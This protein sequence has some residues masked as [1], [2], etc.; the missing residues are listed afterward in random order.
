MYAAGFFFSLRRDAIV[1]HQSGPDD[2]HLRFGRFNL[3]AKRDIRRP[4]TRKEE[5]EDDPSPPPPPLPP[6]ILKRKQFL[7]R[8]TRKILLLLLLL[9]ESI[10]PSPSSSL[11]RIRSSLRDRRGSFSMLL[12]FSLPECEGE[13]EREREWT[14]LAIEIFVRIVEGRGHL[15]YTIP[16]RTLTIGNSR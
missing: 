7:A 5:A 6:Q 3:R 8:R 1:D 14:L 4:T 11:R 16:R 15:R 13:R 10:P 9:R 12:L 2:S